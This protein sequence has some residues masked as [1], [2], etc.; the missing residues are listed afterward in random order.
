MLVSQSQ[1]IDS[2]DS[3]TKCDNNGSNSHSPLDL[4]GGDAQAAGTPKRPQERLS[5]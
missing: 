3:R 1:A 4:L 5:A 2:V